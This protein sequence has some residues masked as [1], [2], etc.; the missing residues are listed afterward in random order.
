ML[1]SQQSLGSRWGP[2]PQDDFALVLLEDADDQIFVTDEILP[3]WR[4]TAAAQRSIKFEDSTKQ[5]HWNMYIYI[6][7]TLPPRSVV[8]SLS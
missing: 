8:L 2:F 4:S 5:S 3:H 6:C 1:K 7:G